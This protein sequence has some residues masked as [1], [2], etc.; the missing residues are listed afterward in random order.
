MTVTY[1]TVI[2][3][4]GNH[5]SIEIPDSV[6][7]TL[8]AHK[9]APLRITV[10]DHT[11]RSTAVGVDGGCRVVF[12]Q[13][14][15]D[16]AGVSEGTIS[17]T[18]ELDTGR[19]EVDVPLELSAALESAGLTDEFESWSYSHRREWARSV[20]DAKKDDTRARRVKAVVDALR[21]KPKPR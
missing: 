15:R 18:L 20:A 17:V 9:R 1:S 16:L 10:N 11:Y 2:L 8:G 19:R 3:R 5:A 7:T 6:L 14:E 4:E 12:P 13:R 21:A